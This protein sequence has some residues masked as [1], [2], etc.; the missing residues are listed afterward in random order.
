[1]SLECKSEREVRQWVSEKSDIAKWDWNIF[2]PD[3]AEEYQEK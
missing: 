2:K 1:M 3:N